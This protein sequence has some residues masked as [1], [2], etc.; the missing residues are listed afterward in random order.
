MKK[1]LLVE[2]DETNRD[3]GYDDFDTQ[4]I[5]LPRLLSKIQALLGPEA[6]S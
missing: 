1:I 5:E 2:D 3:V 6:R 4:P